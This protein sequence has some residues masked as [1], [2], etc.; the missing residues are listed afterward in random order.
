MLKLTHRTQ[1]ISGQSRRIFLECADA[2]EGTFERIFELDEGHA[3][4]GNHDIDG[5]PADLLQI[6]AGGSKRAW[7]AEH[8]EKR[9]AKAVA[10][11]GVA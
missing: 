5:Q 9:D 10:T 1:G 4:P 7:L 2:N 6:I 11:Q 3:V 8:L